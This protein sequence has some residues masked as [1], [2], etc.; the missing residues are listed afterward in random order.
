MERPSPRRT[1]SGTRPRSPRTPRAR[2]RRGARGRGD[3][4]PRGAGRSTVLACFG[5]SCVHARHAERTTA[6]SIASSIVA[7]RV[8]H[9]EGA[10]EVDRASTPSPSWARRKAVVPASSAIAR[11]RSA[12]ARSRSARDVSSSSPSA[13]RGARGTGA[14]HVTRWPRVGCVSVRSRAWSIRRSAGRRRSSRRPRWHPLG[15]ALDAELVRPARLRREREEV[16]ITVRGRA[17][18]SV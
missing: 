13:K 5:R 15:R 8:D 14:D 10:V 1:G 17:F 3:N 12:A 11:R 16:A 6:S 2:R 18:R 4:R 7:P 9:R